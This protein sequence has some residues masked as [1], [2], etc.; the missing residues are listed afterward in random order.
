MKYFACITE[1]KNLYKGTTNSETK[2]EFF[3]MYN[4]IK[5]TYSELKEYFYDKDNPIK[6]MI[7]LYNKQFDVITKKLSTPKEIRVIYIGFKVLEYLV[8]EPSL[9]DFIIIEYNNLEEMENYWI[10]DRI[11]EIIERDGMV[12]IEGDDY[13][14]DSINWI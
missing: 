9:L 4:E 12:E 7:G 14:V 11:E 3:K 1:E 6:E 8:N 5:K 13:T 2:K 10:L